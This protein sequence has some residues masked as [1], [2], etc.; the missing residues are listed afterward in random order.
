MLFG[1]CPNRGGDL[2]K[3][4]SLSSQLIIYSQGPE[5]QNRGF[6]YRVGGAPGVGG[7]KR[8]ENSQFFSGDRPYKCGFISS[9]MFFDAP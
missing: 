4:A 8:G 3:G 1:Q 7:H 5:M 9:L 2:L 6:P